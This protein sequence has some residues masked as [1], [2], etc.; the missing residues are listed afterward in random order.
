M[1]DE[2]NTGAEQNQTPNEG[3]SGDQGV[4]NQADPNAL[5]TADGKQVDLN[6]IMAKHKRT[7][8]SDLSQTKQQLTETQKAQ[9]ELKGMAER[10]TGGEV[11][12]MGAFMSDMAS[13]IAKLDSDAEKHAKD[14]KR[15]AD[16]LTA[17]QTDAAKYRSLFENS[18]VTRAI[19]DAAPVGE[20]A[21]SDAAQRLIVKELSDRVV[22]DEKG[23]VAFGEDG[24]VAFNV[25]ATN[26]DGEVEAR[27][28]SASEAV[29]LMESD[30]KNFGP[31]FISTIKAGAD[32][33]LIDGMKWTKDGGVDPA[34]LKDF[35]KFRELKQKNPEALKK[36]F[37]G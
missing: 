5:F 14:A 16:A 30:V 20:K 22:R 28:V 23:N 17:A 25:Q 31:L 8:Q 37:G 12:D 9:K 7:L 35:A 3:G 18:S 29:T 6:A 19:V 13:T 36:T 33:E 21:Y 32:G 34:D 1:G 10:L 11:E 15:Q 27:Q 2:L 4:Q 24:N 26:E